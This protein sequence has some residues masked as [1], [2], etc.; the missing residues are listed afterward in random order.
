MDSIKLSRTDLLLVW[1]WVEIVF[2]LVDRVD[3]R[4]EKVV[5]FINGRLWDLGFLD[6]M[7]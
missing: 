2:P 4:D 1:G 3:L 7:I 6:F 5:L